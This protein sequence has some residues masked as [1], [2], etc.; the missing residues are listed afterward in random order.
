[1]NSTLDLLKNR[2]S[3]RKYDDRP[4]DEK[5]LD[6]ILEGAM[7]APTAGNMMLYSIL[8]IKD[9]EKK[10]RLSVTCD[11]QPFIAKS[12]L[13]L[14]FLADVQREYDYFTYCDVKSFCKE[15]NL[16]YREAGLASLFLSVSD[17]LIA[18]QNAVIAAEAL[19]IGSCYIGDIMENY[20]IHKEMLGLPDKVFPIGM[21][22]FG[23][24]PEGAKRIITPRF[25]KKHIVFDDE[26]RQLSDDEFKE[27]YKDREKKVSPQNVYGAK[28]FGQLIYS[29]KF[30]SEFF[31]E[32]ERSVGVILKHWN[33]D[34]K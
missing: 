30:G 5:D 6:L 1:M 4:I 28:N 3:L 32:M 2:M 21:L 10:K 20:E 17:A 27:M 18:A 34:V 9:D 22:C 25:D 8:N 29:R 26:Y 14:I 24:Y 31:E 12:P 33:G 13:V 19:G 23:Y 11:N 15:K 16:E 7:R